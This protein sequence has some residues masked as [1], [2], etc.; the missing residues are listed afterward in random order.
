LGSFLVDI[1]LKL[2][3]EPILGLTLVLSQQGVFFFPCAEKRLCR[4]LTRSCQD[5][6][7]RGGL[8]L[9]LPLCQQGANLRF[10]IID[11]L[12][13]LFLWHECTRQQVIDR[14]P[15]GSGAFSNPVLNFMT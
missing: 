7:E 6:W 10:R 8:I 5:G 11:R 1:V 3:P 9:S 15:F 12:G 13:F 4:H 14:N 2:V